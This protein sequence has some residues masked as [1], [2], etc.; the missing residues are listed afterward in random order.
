VTRICDGDARD[1]GI[2]QSGEPEPAGV[3][4]RVRRYP[5]DDPAL[6]VGELAAGQREA[7]LGE[8]PRVLDVG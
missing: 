7:A 6:A 8:L 2:R 3:E 1:R 5:D 4:R